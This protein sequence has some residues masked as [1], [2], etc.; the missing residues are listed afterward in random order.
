M[1]AADL[2][3][4]EKTLSVLSDPDALA[5]N[6]LARCDIVLRQPFEPGMRIAV[7]SEPLSQ[8]VAPGG[9]ADGKTGGQ[10]ALFAWTQPAS[11]K[12]GTQN[13]D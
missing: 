8:P 9:K 12:R 13:S 4:L 2:A 5:D 7:R 10:L 1:G 11:P 6:R 3:E